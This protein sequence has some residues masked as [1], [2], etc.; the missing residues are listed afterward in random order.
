[1]IAAVRHAVGPRFPIGIKLNASDFQTGGFTHAECVEL[2]AML[3]HGGLD[4]LE[5]C[6][7]SLEQPKIVGVTL[8]DEG[9]DSR[10]ASTVAREAYFVAFAG[11]VRKDG[12][13]GGLFGSSTSGRWRCSSA[14]PGPATS[15]SCRT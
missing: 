7:G 10:R 13:R 4:L 14:T 15:V 3:N 2:V 11:K 6:G 1:M 5:L 12:P 9:E 8:K